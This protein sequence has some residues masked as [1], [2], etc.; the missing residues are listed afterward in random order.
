MFNMEGPRQIVPGGGY[1]YLL[2]LRVNTY[3]FTY[4]FYVLA[5]HDTY[6]P[7]SSS[8]NALL[9]TFKENNNPPEIICN[10]VVKI[11]SW[12]DEMEMK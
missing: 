12:N 8:G 5:T 1:W 6:S 10:C 11:V 2:L 7:S 4:V 3:V 9:P